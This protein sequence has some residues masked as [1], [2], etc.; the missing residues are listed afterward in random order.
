PASRGDPSA[1]MNEPMALVLTEN[2]AKAI[3]G[4]EDPIGKVV[5]MDN[6]FNLTVK[7][8]I[9]NIPGNSS[10]K[11]SGV[12]S[13]VSIKK[14]IGSATFDPY[15]WRNYNYET[16]VLFPR[17]CNRLALVKEIELAVKNNAPTD[18][19]KDINIGLYPFKDLYYDQNLSGFSSHGSRERDLALISIA[20]LVLLIA[21]VNYVNLSTARV[22]TRSKETGVR[23]T[24]G[25]S[26]SSLITQFLSESLVVSTISMIT[27]VL[28]ALAM[29]EL[30]GRLIGTPLSIFPN[31]VLT[32]C[33]VLLV[34][35]VIL[36]LLSGM[37]PAFYLTSFEPDAVLKGSIHHGQGKAFLRKGLIVF[38]FSITIALVIST[39]TIYRQMEYVR[40]KPL[41][42]QKG[43]IIYF[44][45]NQE[46]YSKRDVF[47]TR[48][49]ELPSVEK[50][51]YSS[52]VPGKMGMTWGMPLEY[53]GTVTRADFH[54]VPA[55]GDFITLMGMK[56][57]EGRNF[58]DKDS[59]DLGDVIVN[60]AFVKKFG[61]SNPLDGKLTGF[62]E[63]K[64][65]IVGVVKDFN[66]ESLRSPIEPL[67]FFNMPDYIGYGVIK[68]KSA[69]YVGISSEIKEIKTVWKEIAPD[70]PME[71][72]FLDQALERQY[73]AEEQFEA[74][75]FWFSLFAIF[76][77]CLGLFGL[78]AYTVEQRT[79]EISVRKILGATTTGITFMLS[80]QFVTLVLMSNIVAW[81]V[82]YYVTNNWLRNFA[83]RINISPWTF[84][85][86]GAT[87][88]VIALATI[89]FHAIKA[90]TAN[91]VESLRYE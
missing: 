40:T 38:Q 68:A 48:I 22:S 34:V 39:L 67:A 56:I 31:S 85:L 41:G 16:Y 47:A 32:R 30:F 91:P 37:Y 74:A 53:N 23:K 59:N 54:S 14:M 11:F 7:A 69:S 25:A 88:L 17:Q 3:F 27:A 44:P 8:V 70:F 24:I 18:V 20:I 86:S 2:E 43:D 15:S 60:Q 58:I 35:A 19:R 10:M 80:K 62:G 71:Y 6:Q 57:I 82:A 76:I 77:A 13:F 55:S 84:V 83:Y 87:A 33:I 12:V 50:F 49:L 89:S 81:P 4:D 65:K 26:R 46:I 73:R 61:L 28:I 5:K 52:A 90:A 42:F 29:I 79:K 63:D 72:H 64:G 21:M 9:K 1:A 66:F 75:F 51:A 78:T 45:V 36:G